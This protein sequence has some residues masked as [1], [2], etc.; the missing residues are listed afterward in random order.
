M[1]FLGYTFGVKGYKI[2]SFP[3]SCKFIVSK[4]AAFNRSTIVHPRELLK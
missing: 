3:K 4:D 1:H 2:Y